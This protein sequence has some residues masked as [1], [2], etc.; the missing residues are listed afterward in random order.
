MRLRD[1]RI[2]SGATHRECWSGI[3]GGLYGRKPAGREGFTTTKREF[4]S[5]WFA[6]TLALAAGQ[7]AN[8]LADPKRGLSSDDVTS[9][10]PYDDEVALEEKLSWLDDYHC[11]FTQNIGE[12]K[13]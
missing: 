6:G 5:R 1:G 8:G 13:P 2:Y 12:S 11:V 7:C 10:A 4:V 3:K 9:W